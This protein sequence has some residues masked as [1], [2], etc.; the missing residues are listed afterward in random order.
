MIFSLEPDL[1]CCFFYVGKEE[2][3][4]L[5][6]P[7]SVGN[8]LA[9]QVMQFCSVLGAMIIKVLKSSW[10][11]A[12]LES[13]DLSFWGFVWI[14]G[15][16]GLSAVP[17][18]MDCSAQLPGEKIYL[19]SSPI[20]GGEI[21]HRNVR[22]LGCSRLD[23]LQVSKSRLESLKSGYTTLSGGLILF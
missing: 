12:E 14:G 11:W 23:I 1:I 4:F 22:E 21:R 20:H 8:C 2:N 10:V 15:A 19:F 18:P 16:D 6:W 7:L 13:A 17:G 5:F 3:S 9:S